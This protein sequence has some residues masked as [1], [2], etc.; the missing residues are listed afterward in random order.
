MIGSMYESSL[1]SE[2]I[3]KDADYYLEMLLAAAGLRDKRS[4]CRNY[5]NNKLCGDSDRTM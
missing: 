5:P 4:I 1:R 3:Q 2:P